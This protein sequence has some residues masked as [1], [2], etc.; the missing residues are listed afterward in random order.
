[1]K[2]KM[3][4]KARSQLFLKVICAMAMRMVLVTTESTQST[5]FTLNEA[6]LPRRATTP[7]IS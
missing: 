6:H 2:D 7:N 1:M 3:L 5:L 4:E